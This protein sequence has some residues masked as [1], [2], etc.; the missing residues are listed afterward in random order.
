MDACEGAFFSV[1]IDHKMNVSPCSFSAD[2]D[3]YSLK[4]F[5]FYDIWNNKFAAY[6]AKWKSNCHAECLQKSLCHGKCPYYPQIT[7]CYE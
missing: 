4:E 5:K 1:Y 3:A 6:R 2:K 7:I